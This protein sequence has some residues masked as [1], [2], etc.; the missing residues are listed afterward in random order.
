[1]LILGLGTSGNVTSNISIGGLWEAV[2]VLRAMRFHFCAISGLED[3]S[4]RSFL[5]F[6]CRSPSPTPVYDNMGR[7]LNTREQRAKDKL[8]AE[9][10]R[11]VER[12]KVISP[13]Y[14]APLDYRPFSTKKI[15]KIYVPVKEYPDYNFIGLI[16]G[17]RGI[18]QRQMEQETGAKISLR[19]RG[20]VRDGKGRSATKDNN[21]DDDLHVV[22]SGD[23]E[24]SLDHAEALVRR[25]LVPV[26]EGKNDIKRKQL[27]KLA[28]LNGTLKDANYGYEREE[29]HR[30]V[31]GFDVLCRWCGESSHP[32]SDCTMR[33]RSTGT[34]RT[35]GPPSLPN[36]QK[37]VTRE[38]YDLMLSL[39]ED[40]SGMIVQDA[41]QPSNP[42]SNAQSSTNSKDDSYSAFLAS[43][44]V[45][46]SSHSAP[47]NP[48][49]NNNHYNDQFGAHDQ[50]DGFGPSRSSFP[51]PSGATDEIPPW[52][53]D[54]FAQR[55]PYTQPA[56][57][58]VPASA[59]AP[60]PWDM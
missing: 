41:N 39:G 11:L 40:V 25:L 10:Q 27:R 12:A 4:N 52:E 13:S 18:T 32:S 44:G 28:E 2:F 45:D 14:R 7:R 26:E 5:C 60:A 33:G 50:R 56:G 47:F 6:S 37:L 36:G 8:M 17:P 21:E 58:F 46:A 57:P 54:Q 35:N 59:D 24:E 19:G 43:V 48:H 34:A 49:F 38:F 3:E 51:A 15:R 23:S 16:L 53:R 22:I 1:M 31:G 30:R 29:R 55:G 20:S 9:R 42:G